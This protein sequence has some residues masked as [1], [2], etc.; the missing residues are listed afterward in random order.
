LLFSKAF[1]N[2]GF[3]FDGLSIPA[4]FANNAVSGNSKLSFFVAGSVDSQIF[5]DTNNLNLRCKVLA[6]SSSALDPV[7]S[8]SAMDGGATASYKADDR[9]VSGTHP[10]YK[11]VTGT[12]TS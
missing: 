8:D 12:S 4:E 2:Y 11:F 1:V 10:L 7:L 3:N 9:S 5:F 6:T